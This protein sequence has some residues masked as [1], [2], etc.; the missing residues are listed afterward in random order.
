[1]NKSV[2]VMVLIC[3]VLY[4]KSSDSAVIY[5]CYNFNQHNWDKGTQ[6]NGLTNIWCVNHCKDADTKYKFAGTISDFCYCRKKELVPTHKYQDI[7]CISKC[8]G[9][10]SEICGRDF[11]RI[12][13]STIGLPT[14]TVP[15]TNTQATSASF[16]SI[17]ESTT[18]Y[19]MKMITTTTYPARV[20]K[21]M[22]PRKLLCKCPKRLINTKWHFLDGKNITDAEVKKMVVED[23]N[24]NIESE[25]SVDKTTVSK[26]I[27]KKN[28][29]VNK[30]KS[31]QSIGWGCIVFLILPV[32]FLIAIDILNCCIHF[33]SR[34][35]DRKR[36]RISPT[37]DIQDTRDSTKPLQE[38]VNATEN[39][40]ASRSG[41]YFHLDEMKRETYRRK[42]DDNNEEDRD[43]WLQYM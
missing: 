8:P 25:I 5:V 26:E 22:R 9:N 13:V 3:S 40:Y 27:R 1:M 23:F 10:S 21:R 43:K 18:T 35:G 14:E 30:R 11:S 20:T 4:L 39:D 31:S 6:N 38:N 28:S 24:K 32:V 42:R 34:L 29:S 2:I 12:T 15:V 41:N 7:E 17:K 19:F 36:N 33:Q 16:V 37:S